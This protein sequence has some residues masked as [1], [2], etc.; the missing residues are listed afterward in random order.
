[1]LLLESSIPR[2]FT[3]DSVS[4]LLGHDREQ[5]FRMVIDAV[6]SS[7]EINNEATRNT[8]IKMRA[9]MLYNNDKLTIDEFTK[10]LY[11]LIKNE[12]AE[13]VDLI[14]NEKFTF[15]NFEFIFEQCDFYSV[16]LVPVVVN[17]NPL[18]FAFTV[19]DLVFPNTN[20]VLK[21]KTEMKNQVFNYLA[22][23]IYEAS[24]SDAKWNLKGVVS[25]LRAFSKTILLDVAFPNIV[26]IVSNHFPWLTKKFDRKNENLKV[27]N[28]DVFL[29]EITIF[30]NGVKLIVERSQQ[31]LVPAPFF[32]FSDHPNKEVNSYRFDFETVLREIVQTYE[33]REL[34]NLADSLAAV[35]H[36]FV[37]VEIRFNREITVFANGIV[38]DKIYYH[39]GK[40][41]RL[42]GFVLDD[43]EK[44]INSLVD[45]FVLMTTGIKLV[46]IN[47]NEH[48]LFLYY[49]NQLSLNLHLTTY[50]SSSIITLFRICQQIKLFSCSSC[51]ALRLSLK[52]LVKLKNH[53]TI[54]YNILAAK[55]LTCQ[56]PISFVDIRFFYCYLATQSS[57]IK[58]TTFDSTTFRF[59][60][61]QQLTKLRRSDKLTN[62]FL[63]DEMTTF[64]NS[65][66]NEIIYSH[67][68]L[69]IKD[70][71]SIVANF[72]DFIERFAT[73]F[74]RFIENNAIN[75]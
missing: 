65:K 74:E 68:V 75:G 54:F 58:A 61:N 9:K 28:Q 42:N 67:K 46:T 39:Q 21:V 7:S 13:T 2:I 18:E 33:I 24:K 38:C 40:I 56:Q 15:Q 16:H 34:K 51:I 55:L 3:S 41:R 63:I 32:V 5:L 73:S 49:H 36:K 35:K 44:Y 66:K 45:N 23:T 72:R 26:K 14:E 8:F 25:K 29:L 10:K 43:N 31:L 48:E 4:S 30:E 22:S 71:L 11:L 52:Q 57:L 69:Y 19:K 62:S 20:K 27:F 60:L 64:Y 1:M 50:Q 47:Q 70:D 53:I 37:K 6:S 12:I 17:R 59:K